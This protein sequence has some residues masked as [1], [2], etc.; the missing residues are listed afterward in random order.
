VGM[1][2]VGV[3]KNKGRLRGHWNMHWSPRVVYTLLG[4]R[5]YLS[6][7]ICSVSHALL[8]LLALF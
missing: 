7:I 1:I 5:M 3:A 4:P 2:T 6:S 8:V